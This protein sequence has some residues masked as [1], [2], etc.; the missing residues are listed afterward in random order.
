MPYTMET[1]PDAVKKLPP[2]RQRQWLAVWNGAMD[3]CTK[4]GGS[5]QACETRAFKQANGVA[6]SDVGHAVS[7]AESEPVALPGD[8]IYA[9]DEVVVRSG[10]IFRA[11]DYPDKAFTMTS[12]ELARAAE[13][14]TRAPVDLEHVPTILDGKLGHVAFVEAVDDA[15]YGV[16]S[17]P[18]WLDTAIGDA[19]RKVS[20]TWDRETK[21]LLGLALVLSPRVADA[22]LL[23][24]FAE[25]AAKRHDTPH[26]RMALQDIHDTTT[27]GGAV[28]KAANA[29]MNSAHENA[30]IQSIH[31]LTIQHGAQCHAL[32]DPSKPGVSALYGEG[33]TET[34]GSAA[35][36]PAGEPAQKERV[37]MGD[38][39]DKFM[40]WLAGEDEPGGNPNG[41]AGGSQPAGASAASQQT[42]QPPTTV[43]HSAPATAEDPEKAALRQ[44]V[45]AAE[46]EAT[47]LRVSQIADRAGAFADKQVTDRKAFPAER[48]AIAAAFMQ[49][50]LD[51]STIG[52]VR[53]ADGTPGT[54]VLLLERAYEQRSA[55][56]FSADQLPAQLTAFMNRQTTETGTG[57]DAKGPVSQERKDKLLSMSQLGQATL[58]ERNGK[59]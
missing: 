57:A 48:D 11:G 36:E 6:M 33:A 22:A 50:A 5:A 2:K 28:C 9:D 4:G 15:L 18:T 7:F 53:F 56:L 20:A 43:Q 29:P 3:R 27:R 46:Q 38:R 39:V 47:R 14:F 21:E 59:N 19:P 34:A 51:D 52:E 1:L 40:K 31:D 41:A 55:H 17:L 24:S 35:N 23:S 42:V 54:R 49:A 10:L 44:R 37:S 30:A 25:F 26:G 16:V 32:K 12:E 58:K 13:L 8:P 45:V